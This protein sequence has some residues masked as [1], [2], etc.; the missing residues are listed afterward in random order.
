MYC[1]SCC[2]CLPCLCEG[3]KQKR[4]LQLHQR[5]SCLLWARLTPDHTDKQCS[6]LA[7]CCTSHCAQQQ[8]LACN[9]HNS[10]PPPQA[11]ALM[12]LN[13]KSTAAGLRLLMSLLLPPAALTLPRWQQS[14]RDRQ[15][16]G[17]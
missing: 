13:F 5:Q 16:A 17:S 1:R 15:Q 3:A 8:P 9:M 2:M 11:A 10:T 6:R 14:W 7:C 12:Y 4:Q